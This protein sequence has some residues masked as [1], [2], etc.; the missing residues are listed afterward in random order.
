MFVHEILTLHSQKD[1]DR[2]ALT[3]E[4]G[5]AL[6]WGTLAEAT[7]SVV[8]TLTD[9]GL[10]RGDRVAFA[11]RNCLEMFPLY[12][13]CSALG[14]V[15]TPVNYRFTPT[16][17]ESM[18][19]NSQPSFVYCADEF[20]ETMQPARA[21][22]E[23]PENFRLF[24]FGDVL[25]WAASA[26]GPDF[27]RGIDMTGRTEDDVSWICYTG[28]TTGDPK[29]V[30]LTHRNMMSTCL[31][32][33][34]AARPWR[35]DVY[36]AMGPL[37]HIA[38]V[39]PIAYLFLGARVVVMNFEPA[40]ALELIAREQVTTTVATGTIF[41]MLVEAQERQPVELKSLRLIEFGGAPISSALAQRANRLFGCQVAQ[42]YG[43]TEAC[44][45]VTYMYPEEYAAFF[46]SGDTES[47]GSIGKP[48]TTVRV[49]IV[50][51]NGDCVPPGEVGEVAVHGENVMAGYW[52]RPDLTALA[53]RDGW[54]L[55]G[56]LGR[57]DRRGY[58][59]LVDRKKDMIIS[60]G[61]NVYSGEVERVI[62]GFAE[63]VEAVVVGRPD[64]HWGEAVHAVVV[65]APGQS[66]TEDEVRRRC[67]EVLAGYKVPKS[68]EFVSELPRLP[69]GK[70]AKSVIKARYGDTPIHSI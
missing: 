65:L 69:T 14:L 56:D 31:F 36:L 2:I 41:K 33:A 26:D 4:D 44:L 23:R 9:A 63:V 28:G 6:A 12:F 17:I 21:L 61:E 30:M 20:N 62:G 27:D 40:R 68:V 34:T 7:T 42:I 10:S 24:T 51:D 5:T 39:G 13:A 46:E 58:I 53:I 55:T 35:G 19:V 8:N 49:K 64:Q 59:H 3:F 54:L 18:F 50:D 37:F 70:V 25:T 45:P 1:P 43:Q 52:G 47:V 66:C 57:L 29:G 60:G 32:F 38:L 16:E 22:M 11:G 48:V 67:R 15:F